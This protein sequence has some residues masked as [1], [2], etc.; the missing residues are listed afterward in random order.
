[1]SILKLSLP[2]MQYLRLF[3]HIFSLKS[4]DLFH[5]FTKHYDDRNADRDSQRDRKQTSCI[6][7]TAEKL[8]N[9]NKILN[10]THKALLSHNVFAPECKFS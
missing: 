9:E 3:Q 10:I 6:K 1:M 2:H 4:G 8:K 7:N 5:Q